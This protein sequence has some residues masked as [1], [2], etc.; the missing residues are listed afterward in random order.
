MLEHFGLT[1]ED[2]FV[3]REL[4]KDLPIVP[5][6]FDEVASHVG[7]TT[8]Q[9]LTR[10]KTF[11][12]QGKM[13]RFA[14]VLNHRNAGF[15]A[16]AMGVWDVPAERID[17]VGPVMAAF[18]EVSHCYQRPVYADW[19]FSIFTMVHAKSDEECK[20]ILSRISEKSGIANY[21]ALFSTH[22]Y[23]KVRVQYFTDD[24][25]AWEEKYKHL[26]EDALAAIS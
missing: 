23:K 1:N 10:A 12:V 22:E 18:P 3:I 14:A 16:N 20:S 8:E 21:D 15:T 26:A 17:K 7:T 13:R 6:P 2:I 25:K 9:L 11:Q 4:Q 24:Y 5:A 19:P